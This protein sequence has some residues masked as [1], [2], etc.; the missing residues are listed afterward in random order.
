MKKLIRKV[1]GLREDLSI[2]FYIIDFIFRKILRQNGDVR[3]A[4]HHTSTIRCADKMKTGTGT[5][6]GDSPNVYINAFNGI[7]IGDYTNIGPNVSIISAN[8]DLIDNERQVTAHAINIGAYCWLGSG[9]I[10]LPEVCLGDFTIVGA[11]AVVTKSFTA[12]YCVLAGNPAKIIK[13]LNKET[14]ISFVRQKR[15]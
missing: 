3:Y 4:L 13:Q 15:K 2:S 7:T 12:G 9:A 14:C 1:F 6:P 5:W 8:H 10:I 11:G